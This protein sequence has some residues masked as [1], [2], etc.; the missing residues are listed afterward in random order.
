M[1][2]PDHVF[3]AGHRVEQRQ[4]ASVRSP[5]SCTGIVAGAFGIVFG[6]LGGFSIGFIFVPIAALCSLLGLLRGLNGRS[7]SGIG[8]SLL[9]G[10]LT[11]F[12]ALVSPSVWALVAGVGI[13]GLLMPAGPV[14]NSQISS[15]P[16][17]VMRTAPQIQTVAAPAPQHPTPLTISPAVAAA[18]EPEVVRDQ[19]L[20]QVLR[21]SRLLRMGDVC[22]G[23]E[24]VTG[25]VLSRDVPTGNAMPVGV[26]IQTAGAR[27][28][29]VNI[30]VDLNGSDRSVVRAVAA[31]LRELTQTGR[32][33]TI[34]FKS[35]GG[36]GR[37]YLDS[38][39]RVP[40]AARDATINPAQFKQCPRAFLQLWNDDRAAAFARLPKQPC[41]MP[42]ETGGYVCDEDGCARISAWETAQREKR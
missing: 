39:T 7:A 29:Y 9:G 10:V 37:P 38:I 4:P 5:P 8:V 3:P 34:K 41:L 25:R 32:R 11:F 18:I 35:C 31:G 26:A 23:L 27:R 14:A 22:D 16:T 21:I 19:A 42:H 6:L 1:I 24:Q 20:N 15:A 2:L 17:P 33:V 12:G 30:D 28:L 40:D 13:A 36:S